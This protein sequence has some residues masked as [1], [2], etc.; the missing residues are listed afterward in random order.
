MR[1]WARGYFT[2]KTFTRAEAV[3]MSTVGSYITHYGFHWLGLW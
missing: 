3:L 2:E 1:G